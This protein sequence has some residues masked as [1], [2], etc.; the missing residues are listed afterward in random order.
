MAEADL[1]AFH[2]D[3]AARDRHLAEIEGRAAATDSTAHH[4][5]PGLGPAHGLEGGRR[6]KS[7]PSRCKLSLSG[8]REQR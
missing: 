7:L 3:G 6:R 2:P 4:H 8:A 1:A 5:E